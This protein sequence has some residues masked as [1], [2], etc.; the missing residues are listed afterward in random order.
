M[1]LLLEVR[2]SHVYEDTVR[3]LRAAPQAALHC[4]LRIKFTGE[5]GVDEGGLIK[6]FF[7][8]V[9]PKFFRSVGLQV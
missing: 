1:L 6:E 3:Q 7:H 9:L 5:E 2:R 4:P 8:L